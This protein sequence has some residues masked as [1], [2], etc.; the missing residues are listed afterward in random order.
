MRAFPGDRLA[1][2]TN[3]GGIGVLAVDDLLDRGGRLAEVSPALR[4]RLE[5]FF[6]EAG[7]D[8]P[9]CGRLRGM[10][11]PHIDYGRGGDCYAQA[12]KYLRNTEPADVYVVL[13]TSHA[14]TEN[15]FAVTQKSYETPM[16]TLPTDVEFVTRLQR[17][18][19]PNLAKDELV[20]RTEHSVELQT[21]FLKHC[22]KAPCI[23]PVLIGSF[24]SMV[25]AGRSPAEVPEVSDF[26]AALKAPLRRK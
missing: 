24:H 20:H 14:P 25:M 6:D 19:G 16:G 11:A 22:L 15:F 3:G 23:V 18:Y 7:R 17:A 2:L 12:Y 13:G 21:V 1:I 26:I 10:I 8:V 5:G 9:G 4:A